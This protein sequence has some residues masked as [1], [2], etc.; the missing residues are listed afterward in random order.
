MAEEKSLN[1]VERLAEEFLESLQVER[2]AS[3]LTV[4]NYRHYLTH[5]AAWLKNNFSR[6]ELGS[7]TLPTVKK[8][9]LFLAR[10]SLPNGS[11]LSSS[12]QA[13]YVIALRSFL[14]WLVRHD[15]AVLAPEKIDLPKQH[16]KSVK[17]LTTE[18]VERLL[19]Q[20]NA[21][22]PISLRDKA[23]LE[24]L[25]STG[26]RVSEL[27][28]LN[29]EQID[30][31][32]REFGVIGKGG[33]GRVVF[34]SAR[35]AQ[36]LQRYLAVRQDG[37]QPLFIHYSGRNSAENKGEKMRLTVRSVQRLVKKYV[38]RA[39]LPVDATVHTLRHSFATDLLIAGA[40]LRA[41]QEM[42][43]HKNIATTQI[44]THVTNKHLKDVHTAFHGKG[45]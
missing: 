45:R 16:N 34:L 38:R 24:V 12:T 25:F 10:F 21:S 37:W 43:G 1:E 13:Y 20:P 39:Q 17:F 4:R 44:Y 23:I 14:R 33:R 5:F 30:F 18:Q 31:K 11:P 36:W 22:T 42:L 40:D 8:Y 2:Q 6:V 27:V 35:A 26:L 41:V 9:R 29:R 32:R 19:S 15:Y 3:P 7:I 28:R